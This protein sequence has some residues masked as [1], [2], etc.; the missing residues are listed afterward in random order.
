M[1]HL[2][3]NKRK[4]RL[5]IIERHMRNIGSS[6]NSTCRKRSASPMSR[7]AGTMHFVLLVLYRY[8]GAIHVSAQLPMAYRLFLKRISAVFNGDK[9]TGKHQW[10]LP[11]YPATVI[12][13]SSPTALW[14]LCNLRKT[15]E[16]CNAVNTVGSPNPQ[17]S[18][19]ADSGPKPARRQEGLQERKGQG[20]RVVPLK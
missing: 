5:R 17:C 11:I 9:R 1:V 8:C 20:E 14:L 16:W 6:W 19:Y 2:K 4:K 15:S 10:P 18:I 12:Q 13:E 3:I 7:N